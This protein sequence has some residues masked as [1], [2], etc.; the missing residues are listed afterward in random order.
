MTTAFY[1]MT[2]ICLLLVAVIVLLV[3]VTDR[4]LERERKE[5]ASL[6]DR[7]M[8][9]TQP[10]AFTAVKASEDREPA[11]IMYVDEQKEWELSSSGGGRDFE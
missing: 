6:Q 11:R 1:G 10:V 9:V 4:L 7:V 5:R 2:A 3:I 8:S